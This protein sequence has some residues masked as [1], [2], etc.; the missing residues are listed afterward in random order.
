M[1][2]CPLGPWFI[3][4]VYPAGLVL[5]VL[6]CFLPYLLLLGQFPTVLENGPSNDH[7]K[8]HH[9]PELSQHPHG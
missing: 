5:T 4:L 8:S 7:T 2:T 3:L 9:H 6:P 1:E